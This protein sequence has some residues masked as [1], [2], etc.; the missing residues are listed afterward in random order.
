MILEDMIL[1]NVKNMPPSGIRKY[2]D[3]IN[4]MEDVISLGVGE[5]DFVTPWNVIEAGIYSL[6][7][8][9]THYSSN[10][11]FIELRKEISNYLKRRFN[12]TYNPEDEILVTVGGSE[13]IDL[14]LRALV[15]PG[16]EIIIPEPSFVAYK[17][18]ATFCGATPV[19]IN[20]RQEDDFKLTADLLEKAI[21]PKTKVVIIPFPNNPTGAIMTK[22]E[23]KE[24]VEVLKDKDIIILSDE[25]Y[26]E[27]SY[28]KD[29]YSIASFEEV[30]DKTLVING[31]SKAYAMTGW[32][33]GYVCGHPVLIDALKKIHQYALMCSPTTAQFA[34]I[35]ALK[36]GDDSVRE[37]SREYNR[38]RRILVNGFREMGLECFEPLGALYVFPCIKSTG[39]TSDEF[40]ERLLL[41]ENVLAVP[42]NAF[43]ECGEGYIRACYASSTEDLIEAVKRIKRF[44]NKLKA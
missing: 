16:D 23:L 29:H 14:A 31:F 41:E 28:D 25:I 13:G 32:R 15:G 12:L 5:P 35:E 44:V 40:C 21:T 18:C 7:K 11:G 42:G 39:L 3:L 33:L 43:G 9:E 27:L 22:E 26:A 20:L 4:E 8:G 38:R 24:I 6:E 2:F 37:M 17:G 10:A 30:K 34:A 19:I 36:H 1:D